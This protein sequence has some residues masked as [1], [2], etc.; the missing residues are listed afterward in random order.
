MTHLR[1]AEHR[2]AHD[3]SAN[4]PRPLEER[5]TM[6]LTELKNEQSQHLQHILRDPMFFVLQAKRNFN[7]D[8][9]SMSDEV[10]KQYVLTEA[11]Q[12]KPHFDPEDDDD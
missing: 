5:I 3:V 2:E 7:G 12:Y 8:S 10:L 11:I 9:N 6:V 4:Q 1:T